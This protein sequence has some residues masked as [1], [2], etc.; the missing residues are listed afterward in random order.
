MT[1]PALRVDGLGKY[2][3]LGLTHA[4]SLSE[5]AARWTRR[6]RG[7][8]PVEDPVDPA[9]G[10][11]GGGGGG[12]GGGGGGP[13]PGAA[14]FW[15]LRDVS[16]AVAPG[17]VVGVIGRNGA[18]KSTLLKLLSRV[19]APTAGR[20][21]V[22]GRVGSLLEVGTGFHPELTGRENVY[23]NATLLGMSRREVSA[24]LEEI[25]EFSG[26]EKF[27]DTPVKR[28]SSGMT[29]RL[30][31]AV[32]AHLE[33]EV[34]IV[35]EV[36]AVGD[37]EFQKKC[38]GKMKDVAGEGRTVLFVSH[39]M[40][41]VRNLCSR[42]LLL[43]GGRVAVDGPVAEA[44]DRYLTVDRG[45]S[46]GGGLP[47]G[48]RT[49]TGAVRLT[50]LRLEDDAGRELPAAVCGEPVT[51]CLTY[52]VPGPA[53]PPLDV[54]FSV[55]DR[56]NDMIFGLR[57]SDSGRTYDPDRSGG[58]FRCRIPRLPL[59]PGQYWLG[60][61]LVSRGVEVDYPHDGVANFEV[62]DGD[63]FGTG[64]AGITGGRVLVDGE[65]P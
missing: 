4:G 34:L 37:A 36:L 57:S 41:A 12:V 64:R 13:D 25:V 8:P 11:G 40:A 58:A 35:D 1:S 48:P 59:P 39:N 9:A 61:R 7:R 30:G 5:V 62:V 15:A 18:G 32:A 3:R 21:E 51:F 10:G 17:E 33:P 47:P 60:A 28:Y 31:F 24:K 44:L 23:M 46:A 45:A 53:P 6:L 19:T 22:E 42:G 55:Q 20:V 52:A 50:G 38:L 26:V 14:G 49:G 54:G 16:F 29:V 63:F 2:Y 27:L 65:W 43:A 56:L